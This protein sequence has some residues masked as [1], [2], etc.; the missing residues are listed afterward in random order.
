MLENYSSQIATLLFIICSMLNT[1]IA[2][3]QT[4]FRHIN[5]KDGLSQ[6]SVFA[7]AQ[8]HDG[9]MWFGTRDGL[10]KYD[11]YRFTVYR[12]EENN[13]S[14]LI[15]NDVR[16]LYFDD[17][18]NK[19]WVGTVNGLSLYSPEK[20]AFTNYSLSQNSG[21]HEPV[22]VY[23]IYRDKDARLWVATKNGIFLKKS[24]KDTFERIIPKDREDAYPVIN[25]ILRDRKDRLWFGSDQG[26]FFILEGEEGF[27]L[28]AAVDRYSILNPFSPMKIE[29]LSED[30]VGN[31][32]IGTRDKGLIQWETQSNQLFEYR[33]DKDN[34]HSI[35]DDRTKTSLVDQEG[36]LWVGTFF[37]L[38]KFISREEGFQRF[39]DD[40]FIYDDISN[41]S[42]HDLFA[43]RHGGIWVGTYY[44]GVSYM[45][46][47]SNL[48]SVYRKYL[49]QYSISANIV[50]SFVEN[51]EGLM[52]I[53]TE[54]GGL[55]IWDRDKNRFQSLQT[56]NSGISGNVIKTLL[57]DKDK[58]WIGTFQKGLN[59]FDPVSGKIEVFLHEPDNPQS[60]S[61][62]NIYGL[63]K[64]DSLL[65][66]ATYGGGLN[67][68]NIKEGTFTH[69]RYNSEDSSSLNSDLVRGVFRDHDQVMWVSTEHGAIMVESD[70]WDD[71][72]FTHYFENV[73]VYVIHS[74][75][76][77]EVWFG[78]FGEGLFHLDK[79]TGDITQFTQK[80]GLAGNTVFGILADDKNNLWLS[81]DKG[82]SCLKRDNYSF[83]N[84]SIAY[85]LVETEFNFNG[86]FQSPSGEFFFGGVNGFTQFD[87]R[88]IKQPNHIPSVVFTG[89]HA[90]GTDIVPGNTE[91][92]LDKP[93]NLAKEITFPYH[94][95][96]FTISFAALDYTNPRHNKYAYMLEDIDP[97]WNYRIGTPSAT[98]TLQ[99]PG[100]YTFRL[101][102]A[103]SKDIWN[104]EERVLKITVLPPPWKT[105]WAYTLYVL[106]AGLIMYGFYRF[107][108]LRHSYQ[109]EQVTRK[110][111]EELNEMKIRFFTNITHEIR[112]PLT[113]ILG[114]LEDLISKLNRDTEIRKSLVSIQKNARHL[115]N[116]VNQ[117]LEF[118]KLEKDHL[119]LEVTYENLIPFIKEI[120]FFFQDVARLRNIR[121]LFESD[122]TDILLWIDRDKIEKVLFNLLSNAFKFTPDGGNITI[123][124]KEDSHKVT[125]SV[126]DD[127]VGISPDS[128][129]QI[130]RRF[131]EK[132][133]ES[134]T[135]Q[136]KGSGIGLS[137]SREFIELHKGKIKVESVEGEGA[138]FFI[139][140]PKGKN[141]FKKDEIITPS[142]VEKQTLFPHKIN[143]YDQILISIEEREEHNTEGNK[144]VRLLIVED[145]PELRAYIKSIFE[146]DYE[147]HTADNGSVG[148]EVAKKLLP[149]LIICD[150][151]M[152][153]IDGIT[154]CNII[155]SE[156]ETSHIPVIILTARSNLLFRIEG[157]ET[158][159]DDY[160]T[161][162]FNKEELWLKAKNMVSSRQRLREKF[163]RN[164]NFDPKE[165]TVTTADEHFLEK[166]M[167]VV[168]ENIENTAFSVE[169]FAEELAVSRPLLFLKIKAL[170][171][172]TP[173]NFIKSVRLK[174]AA[175]L[176]KQ[177][178]FQISEIAYMVGFKDPRYFSKCFQKEFGKTP[179]E[180]AKTYIIKG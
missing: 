159:A 167:Q 147:V 163:A 46:K 120:F 5:R 172:Q 94:K 19:L 15:F 9:F 13:D 114:P 6:R 96:I 111:R 69:F 150:V 7:I 58:L 47:G 73:P 41:N 12:N 55:N 177:N 139:E 116:L 3:E 38:N 86:Y 88:E 51:E 20:D 157:L 80:D 24:D 57:W 30:S 178:E 158:G 141:H 37:G 2:Q 45:D 32:W 135:T 65:W 71:F 95:A 79:L 129:D 132:S 62:N 35:S 173:N 81:T 115:L 118:R 75:Q 1:A 160:L 89:L 164:H 68:Y 78:T 113:L 59:R 112:T 99:K 137:I 90:F 82:I 61:N 128:V 168:E 28:T 108:Q 162:P 84:Y 144:N 106:V 122:S 26:L 131:Y 119:S 161:K 171:N 148:I 121:F 53:G 123:S 170:T 176:L 124:V 110:E 34:P 4:R 66:I 63:L 39:V 109:L 36:N 179:S 91:G 70:D 153:E 72:R 143:G 125:M 145:N 104:P 33:F 49:D 31:I 138:K 98:Y 42:V 133:Y 107:I 155:K 140:L 23:D 87:P 117:L 149:D 48:F 154:M 93:L 127:G 67:L 64:E 180:F 27:L 77:G 136:F 29:T 25:T 85:G 146:N 166:I 92:I 43:D 156:L 14:S 175:Q 22:E 52:Y 40:D 56:S 169:Q 18:I 152:P 83:L 60:L 16:V 10:N 76:P 97:Q 50:S 165:I 130:F 101:K 174:R 74:D 105:W 103:N 54:G 11:G 44:G 151:M 100:K 17:D 134:S 21:Q 142:E 102:A 126:M 8:D